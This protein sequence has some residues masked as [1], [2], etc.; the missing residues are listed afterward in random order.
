MKPAFPAEMIKGLKEDRNRDNPIVG[1]TGKQGRVTAAV[2][3]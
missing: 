2:Q 1:H 3:P